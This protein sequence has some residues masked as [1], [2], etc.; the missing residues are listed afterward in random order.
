MHVYGAVCRFV[1]LQVYIWSSSFSLL[2]SFCFLFGFLF[3]LSLGILRIPFFLLFFYLFFYLSL[4]FSFITTQLSIQLYQRKEYLQV[5]PKKGISSS[6]QQQSISRVTNKSQTT[7]LYIAL[8]MYVYLQVYI[9]LLGF[10]LC[11]S[12]C[13]SMELQIYLSLTSFSLEQFVAEMH[14]FHWKHSC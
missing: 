5:F 2:F 6:T 11:S 8:D 14:H 4:L 1:Y 12:F 13:I 3:I 10:D 7:H 9:T